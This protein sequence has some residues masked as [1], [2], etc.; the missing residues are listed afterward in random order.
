MQN[1]TAIEM[2]SDSQAQI[3]SCTFMRNAVAINS[4]TEFSVTHSAFL[5]NENYTSIMK[6][7][8]GP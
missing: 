8:T 6:Y 1:T 5:D 2:G 3:D 4:R 7:P